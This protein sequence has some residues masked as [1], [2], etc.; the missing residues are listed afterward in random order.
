M[1]SI[2]SFF[3]DCSPVPVAAALTVPAGFGLA[4]M[5]TPLFLLWFEPHQ[6][7]AGV[8]VVHGAHNAMKSRMLRTHID[9][10]ALRRFG[11]ALLLGALIGALLQSV[12]PAGPLLLLRCSV[13][14]VAH[15]EVSERGRPS[16][17]AEIRRIR[18]GF[19]GGLTGHQGVAGDVSEAAFTRQVRICCMPQ[20]SH[21]SLMQPES[22]FI[23]GTIP[24]CSPRNLAGFVILHSRRNSGE[25][26][27]RN[28]KVTTYRKAS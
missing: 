20:F 18:L 12:I 7:I 3:S 13:D 5:T 8:A 11:W 17:R 25:C 16:V 10:D 27:W 26:G 24:A 1:T 15:L 28:G 2:R 4:T 6:A 19:L 9:R 22:R 14:R 23:C 21:W